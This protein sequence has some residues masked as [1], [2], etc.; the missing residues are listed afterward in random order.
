MSRAGTILKI[1]LTDGKIEKAP[2]AGYTRDYIGGPAIGSRL[3]YENVS[4]QA[5][6]RIT[7]WVSLLAIV[8]A[9]L[10]FKLP[11]KTED[12]GLQQEASELSVE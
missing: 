4:P 8:P 9:W 12:A 10:K 5:P 6:F 11:K 2:T 1:D 3:I 7:A